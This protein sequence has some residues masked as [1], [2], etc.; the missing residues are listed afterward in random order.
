VYQ[1]FCEGWASINGRESA[2]GAEKREKKNSQLK[3][4]K[5]SEMVH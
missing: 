3:Y 5:L 4:A 1:F 2:V